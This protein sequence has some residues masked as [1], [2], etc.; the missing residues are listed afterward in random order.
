MTYKKTRTVLCSP[1]GDTYFFDI[2]DI[3]DIVLQGEIFVKI[4]F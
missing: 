1:D 2:F 3:V 4:L